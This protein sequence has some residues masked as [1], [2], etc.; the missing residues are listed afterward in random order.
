VAE[1]H[2]SQETNHEH[3][4]VDDAEPSAIAPSAIV[5]R[6]YRHRERDLRN[7][8][9]NGRLV[10]DD[11]DEH[12]DDCDQRRRELRL[13]RH[14]VALAQSLGRALAAYTIRR[15]SSLLARCEMERDAQRPYKMELVSQIWVEVQTAGWGSAQAP[16]EEEGGV[17]RRCRG[18]A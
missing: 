4:G 11:N 2:H 1:V 15:V 17:P 16:D 8:G 3:L 13:D 7:E 14:P 5:I 18:S 6:H 10:V 12:H 9:N